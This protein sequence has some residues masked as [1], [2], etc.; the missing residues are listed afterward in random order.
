V[1]IVKS[2]KIKYFNPQKAHP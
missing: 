2:V 1:K